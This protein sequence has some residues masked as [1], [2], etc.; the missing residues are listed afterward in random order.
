MKC[1]RDVDGFG[2]AT[3]AVLSLFLCLLTGK[4]RVH[5]RTQ[6]PKYGQA[7]SWKRPGLPDVD[8]G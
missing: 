8:M 6:R 7:I 4:K 5:W 2:C 3:Q 1:G